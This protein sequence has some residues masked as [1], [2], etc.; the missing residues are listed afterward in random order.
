MPYAAPSKPPVL[1]L[2]QPFASLQDPRVASRTEHPLLT[3]VAMALVGVLCGADGWDDLEEIARDREAWFARLV[4]M[5]N[6]VPSADT[7]RRV[8]SAL[9]PAAFFDCVRSWVQSL[10]EPLDGQ[11][12]AFDGKTIRGALKR[13]PWSECLHQVHVW[14]CKQRLLLAQT[15]VAGAPEESVAVR[16]LLELV[17]LR[18]AIATGDAAHCSHETARAVLEAGGDDLLH[19]K[20][21]RGTQHEAVALFFAAAR[22]ACFAGIEARRCRVAERGHGRGEVR[23][24]WSVDARAVPLPGAPWPSLRSVTLIERTRVLDGK[25]TTERH[26]YLSSLPPS[27]RRIAA[28]AREH[29]RIENQRHWVLDVEMGEDESTTRDEYGAQNF[30]A[31]RRVSL[32]MLQRDATL[33]RGLA[34]K[35]AKAARNIAYLEHVLTLG[36]PLRL[37]RS[38]Y[39]WGRGERRPSR[40]RCARAAFSTVRGISI[41][42]RDLMGIGGGLSRGD[43]QG[44]EQVV[45]GRGHPVISHNLGPQARLPHGREHVRGGGE[46]LGPVPGTLGRTVEAVADVTEPQHDRAVEQHGHGRGA[47]D[48]PRGQPCGSSKPKGLLLPW[49][50]FSMGHRSASSVS[51]W[52]AVCSDPV[53]PL[54]K[55]RMGITTKKPVKSS[56][57]PHMQF[58]PDKG[59]QFLTRLPSIGDRVLGGKYSIE[60]VL[61]RGGMG[62]V[63]A[64]EHIALGKQVAFKF[65]NPSQSA[66]AAR[67]VR[68]ARAVARIDS[69]HVVRVTDVGV[70]ESGVVYMLM[71]RLHGEDAGTYMRRAGPLPIGEAVL[72]IGQACDALAAAQAAGVIHR[73]IKPSNL[74]L[75]RRPDDTYVVK[76]LD[77]GISKL[78]N[79]DRGDEASLTRSGAI[80]GS[81]LYMSPE[82]VRDTKNVD[83]RTDFWS[84]GMVLY[85]LLTGAPMYDVNT[86]P[87]LCMAIVNDP[88]SPLRAKRPAR[89]KNSKLF[90]FA[91]RRKTPSGASRPPSSS[92]APSPPSAPPRP[93]RLRRRPPAG[94]PPASTRG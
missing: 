55:E 71:E 64:A 59:H 39:G 54:G 18:G 63:M 89:P 28:A 75:V 72:Y 14:S 41:E 69:E 46:A 36:I 31:L 6:G 52:A 21:N 33:Q 66:N 80:L 84:L 29:W 43:G 47:P 37:V 91:A 74:F 45:G 53:C 67:F 38:P 34:A 13:T 78:V 32:M 58:E 3:I 19:W 73:D 81:P 4:D 51:T 50:A 76:V 65:L 30:G 85:E 49:V 44:L 88:P 56:P 79:F 24:A 61:G 42:L 23:E 90:C 22:A 57:A 40:V 93:R 27:V 8:L 26:F 60:E 87:A 92:P 9:R 20:A 70:L 11:V 62:V 2:A 25:G 17:E 86:F 83:T 48:R 16:R 68:E 94:S 35:R 5:P 82:Q 12:V 15:G 1:C 7:F 10:A 77:F